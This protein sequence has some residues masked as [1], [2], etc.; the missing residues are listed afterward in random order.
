MSKSLSRFLQILFMLLVLAGIAWKL[1]EHNREQKK[2]LVIHSYNTDAPWVNDV[3]SG[4]DRAL[5][6]MSNSVQARRHYM[7]LL[8]H[9]DCNFYHLAAADAR[10]AIEDWKPDVIVLVDD[11]AQALIGFQNLQ[12]KQGADI[13]GVRKRIVDQL[14]DKRCPKQD[15]KFFGLDQLNTADKKPAIF[16]AGVNGDVI[17][18]GY[19]Q[20][21][22]VSGIF[23]HKNF[24]ALTETLNTVNA[25]APEHAEAV[26]LLNDYSATA[27]SE[28]L[29]YAQNNWAPLKWLPPRNATTFEEWQSVVRFASNA[30][31]ML[32]IAN[33]QNLVDAQGRIVPA[34]DVIAWTERNSRYPA[35]G[36]ATNFVSDGG[37][38]TVAI[39]GT[40]QG[41][42][43]MQLVDHYLENGELLPQREAHQFLVGL[44]QPLVR[45]RQ[46]Q[47]PGIYEAF[48]REIGRFIEVSENIYRDS[49]NEK[50]AAEKK[51]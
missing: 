46:L 30:G 26:Q 50:A 1:Y 4:I 24:Q 11:L 6:K 37:M 31:A 3:D 29:L 20:A 15:A 36:A 38:I 10:L 41:E 39:S 19:D 17:R 44:N 12:W 14:T 27:L 23:E 43:V 40:E 8:N 9:P 16:F 49:D 22:N 33:Y 51:K 18:Y 5:G 34:R 45:K 2:V 25:A 32:L 47:L 21:T 42:V 28:N 13:E 7:N 48:S 35:V